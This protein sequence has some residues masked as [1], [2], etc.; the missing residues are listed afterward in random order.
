MS[1]SRF[2]ISTRR[3]KTDMAIIIVFMSIATLRY[4]CYPSDICRS[5]AICCINI[6]PCSVN[7]CK[8]ELFFFFLFYSSDTLF[9]CLNI[10]CPHEDFSVP[11]MMRGV[12]MLTFYRD[13]YV[14]YFYGLVVFAVRENGHIRLSGSRRCQQAIR[15]LPM[16]GCRQEPSYRRVPLRVRIER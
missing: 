15:F 1:T 10:F 11:F 8:S 14:A 4:R 2:P 5:T 6:V 9:L 12:D 13:R 3:C 16:A 7:S